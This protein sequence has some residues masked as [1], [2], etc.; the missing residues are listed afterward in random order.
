MGIEMKRYIIGI[1]GASGSRYGIRTAEALLET[2]AFVHMVITEMGR[3]VFAFETEHSFSR[4]MEWTKEKYPNQI[5]EDEIGDLFAGIASGSFYSDG[6]AVVPCSMSTM[7]ELAAG[8][9][10]N[11]LTRAADV[12]LKQRTPLILVPRETPL[13]A[14]HLKN[15]LAL[16][17]AGAHIVP[18]MPGFYQKPGSVED[19]I[20]FVAGKVLDSFRIENKLYSHWRENSE[21]D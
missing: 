21:H 7:G 2:G 13:S 9:T 18:A 1:T 6:M 17:E 15:M 19:M 3:K 20:D 11:L 8:I 4:W 14:V 5:E 16:S 12:A 10:K